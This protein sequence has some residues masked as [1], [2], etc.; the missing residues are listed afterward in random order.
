[1]NNGLLCFEVSTKP[2]GTHPQDKAI[3]LDTTRPFPHNAENIYD[4]SL[5]L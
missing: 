4:V 1:M 2:T 3:V 5:G